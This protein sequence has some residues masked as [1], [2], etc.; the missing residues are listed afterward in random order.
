MAV[1]LVTDVN[2]QNLITTKDK[3]RVK[4]FPDWC[5]SCKLF[6]PNYKRLSGD[7]RI[8]D[9]TFLDINAEKNPEL[10]K[11]ARV[12]NLPIFDVLKNGELVDSIS[13]SKEE[14]VVSLL[15]KLN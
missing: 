2:F 3:V 11:I 6:P 7:S 10:R 13:A 4:Y 5:G 9:I 15:E 1:E 14:A 8:S 12:T